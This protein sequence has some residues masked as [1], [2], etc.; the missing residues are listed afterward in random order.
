MDVFT[1]LLFLILIGAFAIG[2]LQRKIPKGK[3]RPDRPNN[4]WDNPSRE[5]PRE[6]PV[7]RAKVPQPPRTG[8]L[9][10]PAWVIDGDTIVIA[11]QHIRLSGIDAPEMDHPYGVKAKW[12]L[13]ALC[14]GQIIRAEFHEA[15]SHDREV[16]TCYLPDGRDLSEE[17]VRLGFAIDW[18]KYSGGKYRDFETPDARK[19]LWRAAARQ[20]GMMPPH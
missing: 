6:T 12:A 13:V 17:M 10:G 8:V 11:H 18:P 19:K 7:L 14:K 1:Q 20:K 15:Q 4:T 3:R 5:L 9:K 2:F 16:A